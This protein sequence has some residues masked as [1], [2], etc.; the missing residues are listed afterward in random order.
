MSSPTL[1]TGLDVFD[2]EILR[3]RL[4]SVTRD[5]AIALVRTSGSPGL[6]DAKDFGCSLYDG[7]GRQISFGAMNYIHSGSAMEGLAALHRDYEPDEIEPGDVFITNDPHWAGAIHAGDITA[8]RPIFREGELVA[9]AANET[10]MLDFG[11]MSPGTFA[12]HA[13]ECYQEALRLPVVK[14]MRAGKIDKGIWNTIQNNVR[15]S[16]KV[17]MDMRSLLS[18]LI[19][20]E[21]RTLEIVDLYGLD[22]FRRLV[23]RLM[24][25]SEDATRR[26]IQQLPNGTYEGWDWSEHDG[27]EDKLFDIRAKMVVE[28]D[29]LTFDLSDSSE[30]AKGFINSTRGSVLSAMFTVVM[31]QLLFDVPFNAGTMRPIS[32]VT[33]PG[34]IVDA[35][36]P[37]PV[38][39]GYVEAS[40][41]VIDVCLQALNRAIA[42]SSGEIRERLMGGWGNC[43]P[44]M[45]HAGIDQYGRYTVF[46]N[47]D[48]SGNGGAGM[49]G[50]DGCPS[51]GAGVQVDPA[52]PDVEIH[53]RNYPMLFL[54]RRLQR[55]SGGPGEF[56]GGLGMEEAWT[57]YDTDGLDSTLVA[58]RVSVPT[59]GGFGG[60][61]AG[62]SVMHVVRGLA[63]EAADVARNGR[64]MTFEDQATLLMPKDETS[65]AKGDL[66]YIAFGGGGGFGDPLDRDPGRVV[67]DIADGAVDEQ[68]ARNAYGVVLGPDGLD[69]AATTELRDQL[70]ARRRVAAGA[71]GSIEPISADAEEIGVVTRGIVLARTDDGVSQACGRCRT[72]LGSADRDWRSLTATA[73][74]DVT[75]DYVRGLGAVL[76]ARREAPF[77]R[78]RM[79]LCPCCGTSFETAV[80]PD[81]HVMP[82][83]SLP[84]LAR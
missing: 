28:D 50:L 13:L 68:Q 21:Q 2:L 82:A 1:A 42:R 70:R 74:Y 5:M 12:P 46:I 45:T 29:S 49:A 31:R 7:Q 43:W 67:A 63:G 11:G 72:A 40:F 3:G 73:E 14:L 75:D 38:G 53:E 80:V 20:A 83:D 36:M 62:S 37:A 30:Q 19:V 23:D 44:V 25:T 17:G 76:P 66:L 59:P 61:P 64:E 33:K 24:E 84:S 47:M 10:H 4:D 65:V 15:V 9:W 77:T 69:E 16:H 58:Q 39:I 56:R 71:T 27:H 79:L 32:L 55:N 54:Y 6:T 48:G 52:I 81:G 57:P 22:R 18:A 51:A 35:E 34:T 60:Y 8:L 78:W 41:K 26:R